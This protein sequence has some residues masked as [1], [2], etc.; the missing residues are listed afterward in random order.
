MINA[1]IA[2]VLFAG[3][4][5]AIG[6]FYVKLGKFSFWKLAANLP[7]QAF[8]YISADPAWEIAVGSQQTPGKD[9]VG[10]FFLAVPALGQTVKLYARED[11]IENSQRRFI[12]RYR[13]LIPRRGFPVL[14]LVAL[15]YPI[16]A[17][18]WMDSTPASPI[19]ILG[20]GFANL[21]YLFGAAFVFPGHFRILGFDD[22]LP[23]LVAGV[24]SWVVGLVLSN[25]VAA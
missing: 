14:S 18:L 17:M 15:L 12:E 24:L 22:R 20:Y 23:T 6:F 2:V 4:L 8:E 19:L 3:V 21:G 5:G 25:I 11:Q 13:D 16:A 10:P 1:G 9:F 7:E